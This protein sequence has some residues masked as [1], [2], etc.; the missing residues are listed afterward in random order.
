MKNQTAEQKVRESLKTI[1]TADNIAAARVFKGF[2]F[3]TN[4]NGW[5][6]QFFGCNDHV[7]LGNSVTDVGIFCDSVLSERETDPIGYMP[8]TPF[9]H[10]NLAE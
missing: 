2:A 8:F 4:Q 6:I 5:H 7:Y 9:G 10:E 3:D 1:Y